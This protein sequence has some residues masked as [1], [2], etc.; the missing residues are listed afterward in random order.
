M[1]SR[2]SGK[3]LIKLSNLTKSVYKF[4]KNCSKTEKSGMKTAKHAKHIGRWSLAYTSHVR[5]GTSGLLESEHLS[6]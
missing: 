6:W 2:Y 1:D 4:N 5:L 3:T